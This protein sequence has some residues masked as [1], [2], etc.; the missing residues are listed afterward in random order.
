LLADAM[1][2]PEAT[3]GTMSWATPV[4]MTWV[5]PRATSR[6]VSWAMPMEPEQV[7]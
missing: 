3:A 4:A 7:P 5:T 2:R 1:A 6:A